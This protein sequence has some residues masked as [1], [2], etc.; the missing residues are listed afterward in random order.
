MP[1]IIQLKGAALE[2]ALHI[3]EVSDHHD[4]ERLRLIEECEHKMEQVCKHT[5]RLINEQLEII[6]DQVRIPLA[7]PQR[8][9]RAELDLRYTSLGLAFVNEADDTGEEVVSTSQELS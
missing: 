8:S 2:A 7:G 6:S 9:P 3:R 1:K 4:N 5:N